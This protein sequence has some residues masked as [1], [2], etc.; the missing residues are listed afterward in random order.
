MAGSGGTPGTYTKVPLVNTSASSGEDAEF[1]IVVN[2]SG[3][4]SSVTLT[5]EGKGY[6]NN[7]QLD[8]VAASDIGGVNGFYLTP[9]SINQ[10]FT[11]RGTAAH[12][13]TIGDEVVILSLIHI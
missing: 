1:T 2:E 10:E 13:L 4:V 3:E 7:E 5:K 6:Y 12:Q 8:L 9:N 11:G